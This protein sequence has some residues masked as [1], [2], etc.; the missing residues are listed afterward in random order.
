[1]NQLRRL[2]LVISIATV[3]AGTALAGQTNSST[4]ADPGITGAPPCATQF[5]V[6][7]GNEATTLINEVEVFV[8]EAAAYGIE[9]LLTVF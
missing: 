6:E 8:L 7:E 3:L 9:S 1:M 2:A 5:I 4:C